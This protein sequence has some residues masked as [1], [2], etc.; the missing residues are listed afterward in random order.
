MRRDAIIATLLV[1]VHHVIAFAHGEAHTQLGVDLAPWQWAYVYGVITIAPVVATILYWTR[2]QREGALLLGISMLG[3]FLFGVY[4][5]F[6]AVSPDH[7]SHLPP[8]DA[9]GMFVATAI[10]LAVTEAAGTAFGFWSW[11]QAPATVHA[12]Q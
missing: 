5:H 1:V 4:H 2:W 7:V 8:G 11:R 12:Q 9:Q 3:S 10:L 6:I